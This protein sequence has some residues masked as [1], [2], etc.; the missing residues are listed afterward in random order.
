MYVTMFYIHNYLHLSA[1]N[2]D[3]TLFG[4]CQRIAVRDSLA[5]VN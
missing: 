5:Y 1:L 3:F 4:V 2:Y